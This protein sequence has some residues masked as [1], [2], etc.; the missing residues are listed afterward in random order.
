M[1]SSE[2]AFTIHPLLVGGNPYSTTSIY[3]LILFLERKWGVHYSWEVLEILLV[4]L[5][6]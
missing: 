3:A 6:N 5:R 4:H 2:K 1:K